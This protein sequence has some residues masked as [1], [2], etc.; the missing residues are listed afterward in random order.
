MLIELN[1][2]MTTAEVRRAYRVPDQIAKELLSAL[3]VVLEQSD[4]TRIHL[5]SEVDAVVAEFSRKRRRDVAAANLPE[6]GKPKRKAKTIEIALYTHELK[7]QDKTKTWKEVL[8]AC[9]ERWPGSDHLK[10]V[11]QI[12]ATYRRH[13][14][15]KG[16][17]SN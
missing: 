5:E 1:R 17:R 4:G 8:R 3:P 11:D 7:S 6:N 12:R 9:R 15:S 14:S 2:F 10:N 13:F 16:R